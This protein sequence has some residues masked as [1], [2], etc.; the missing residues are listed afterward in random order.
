MALNGPRGDQA[1]PLLRKSLDHHFQGKKWHFFTKDA[2]YSK[3]SLPVSR[4]MQKE[5]QV[6]LP[7]YL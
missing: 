4:I 1:V 5:Q 2:S 6:S 7:L 3:K